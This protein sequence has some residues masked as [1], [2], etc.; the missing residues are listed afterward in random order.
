MQEIALLSPIVTLQMYSILVIRTVQKRNGIQIHSTA[1]LCVIILKISSGYD[2]RPAFR[3]L[4]PTQTDIHCATQKVKCKMLK[5]NKN[6]IENSQF[7]SNF[8]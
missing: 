8:K 5:S 6:S 1:K 3:I 4:E 2:Q 7:Y